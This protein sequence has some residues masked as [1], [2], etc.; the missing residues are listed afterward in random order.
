MSETVPDD[1]GDRIVSTADV[2]GGQPRIAGRRIGVLSI[3]E[4][5]DGRGLD[6][7]TVADRYDLD[8]ADVYRALAYYY[9]HPREMETVRRE[10][11]EAFE[12]LREHVDRPDHVVPDSSV[13]ES[14]N[15]RL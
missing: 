5:V 8:V 13:T 7:H 14:I 9:E 15:A 3:H 2:L 4:W 1:E 12:R 10:R 11:T 6:P